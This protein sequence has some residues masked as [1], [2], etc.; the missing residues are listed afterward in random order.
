MLNASWQVPLDHFLFSSTVF[1]DELVCFLF[2]W[3]LWSGS[4]TFYFPLLLLGFG[5]SKYLTWDLGL[6]FNLVLVLCPE[7]SLGSKNRKFNWE[8]SDFHSLYRHKKQNYSG[9]STKVRIKLLKGLKNFSAELLG[10]TPRTTLLGLPRR[11]LSL[12][13]LFV[14]D[15]IGTRTPTHNHNCLSAS[16]KRIADAL[17][18]LGN[19]NIFTTLTERKQQVAHKHHREDLISAFLN[20]KTVCNQWT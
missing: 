8:V 11:L 6:G 1:M 10:N 19:L 2:P 18:L 4:L 17:L 12:R 16:T 20:L 5:F 15:H 3:N 14:L 9:R 13:S 7:K